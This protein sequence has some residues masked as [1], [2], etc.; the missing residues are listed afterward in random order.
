MSGHSKWS[1]IKHKKGAADAKRG[2]VF[3]MHAKLITIAAQSGADPEMN[4]ALRSAID[5]AKSANVPNANIDRAVKK[6]GGADKDAANYEEIT[7][8]AMGPGGTAFM[9]DVITDNKLRALTNVKTIV[10]KRGGNMG[11]SGSVAWKF[12]KKAM[13]VVDTAGTDPDEAELLLIDCG[14]DDLQP[15]EG[16]EFEL[17]AAADKLATVRKA[18]EAAGFKVKKDELIWKAKDEVKVDDVALAKKI[19]TLVEAVEEDEDVSQVFSNVDF[20]DSVLAEL[21]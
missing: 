6:G 1:S 12:E 15:G 14:A 20:D 13:L 3:T 10:N 8:E 17:Y 16:S 4:P 5:R 7:Y 9:I 11:S 2:K 19:V 18:A 21:G